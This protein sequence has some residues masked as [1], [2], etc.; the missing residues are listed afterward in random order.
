M[1][2]FGVWLLIILT[3]VFVFTPKTQA[4]SQGTVSATV[5]IIPHADKQSSKLNNDTKKGFFKSSSI[6]NQSIAV[7]IFK[8]YGS[9]NLNYSTVFYHLTIVKSLLS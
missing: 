8:Q 6:R 5:Q 9:A 7:F 3:F 1:K 4:A 2:W